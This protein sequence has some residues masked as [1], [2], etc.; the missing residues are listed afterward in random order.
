MADKIWLTKRHPRGTWTYG[1]ARIS[2]KEAAKTWPDTSILMVA[3]CFHHG[4]A[5]GPVDIQSSGRVPDRRE[6]LCDLVSA[7]MR[8]LGTEAVDRL[9]KK[10][11]K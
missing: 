2:T 1:L 3:E 4:G 6:I 8:E 5:F 7:A 10:M 9:K 11:E